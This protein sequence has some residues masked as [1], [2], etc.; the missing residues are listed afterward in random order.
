MVFR[1]SASA[2]AGSLALGLGVYATRIEPYRPVLRRLTLSVPADWPRL[3]ILHLSDIHVHARP[4]RLYRAQERFLRSIGG[5]P[6]VVCVTGDVCET[7]RGVARAT[8]LLKQL[9]PRIATIVTLGNHE[10]DA[11]VPVWQRKRVWSVP[12]QLKRILSL[13]VGPLEHSSGTA[14]SR[15]I[16]AAFREAGLAVLVNEGTRLDVDGRSLWVA[17]T[18]STWAG[19]TRAVDAVKGRRPDEPC[20]ALIHEPEGVFSFLTR[21]AAVILAGHTH[22]GQVRI[23]FG[24]ALYSHRMDPRIRIASGLQRFGSSHLHI[25]PG[26]GQNFPLRF[27]CPPEAAWIDCIP[28][29]PVA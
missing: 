10:H 26:L 27:N 24:N 2:A 1:L 11:P 3:S 5:H 16:A 7:L 19:R 28:T 13:L 15:Q 12:R 14:E 25:S 6:D 22:G 4:D 29:S 9:Q 21:G 17:G 23:P 20:L 18:D 8:A